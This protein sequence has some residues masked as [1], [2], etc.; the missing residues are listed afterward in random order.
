MAAFADP[1]DAMRAGLAVQ[2]QVEEFRRHSGLGEVAIKVGLH[3]GACIAVTL[4][5]RLDYFGTMVNLAARLQGLARSGEVVVSG[6]MAEDP[7]VAAV[8][9]EFVDTGDLPKPEDAMVRGL[10][11]PVTLIR[12]TPSPLPASSFGVNA[13][14]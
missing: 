11:K 7:G 13:K 14:P 1:A 3:S 2:R 12:L 10:S 4:N 5:D 8:L 6:G 9:A